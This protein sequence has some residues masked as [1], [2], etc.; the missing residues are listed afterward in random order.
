MVHENH[1]ALCVVNDVDEEFCDRR[2]V[3]DTS[4]SLSQIEVEVSI[5]TVIASVHV[6]NL[7]QSIKKVDPLPS[8]TTPISSLYVHFCHK[9]SNSLDIIRW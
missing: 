3:I 1:S 5:S 2:V 8:T 9:S 4:K 6:N 7:H